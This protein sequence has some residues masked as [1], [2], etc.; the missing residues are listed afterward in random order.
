[1]SLIYLI[2]VF[3]FAYFDHN[4]CMHHALHVLDA[5]IND[6][7]NITTGSHTSDVAESARGHQMVGTAN[8]DGL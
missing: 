5:P 6:I 1:M 4:Q 8:D 7:A 3:C 2:D